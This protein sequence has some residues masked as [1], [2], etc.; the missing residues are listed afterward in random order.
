MNDPTFVEAARS[1]A[2]RALRQDV[3]TD[4]GR[5]SWIFEEAWSAAR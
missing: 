5:L 1:F 2:T 4:A 3:Q